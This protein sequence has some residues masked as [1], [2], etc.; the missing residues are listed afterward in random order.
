[1]VVSSG[2]GETC[3]LQSLKWEWVAWAALPTAKPCSGKIVGILRSEVWISSA[4]A[5]E[6][7]KQQRHHGIQIE[8]RTDKN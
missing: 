5:S 3:K 8:R 6:A 2:G 4:E 1:M 7:R